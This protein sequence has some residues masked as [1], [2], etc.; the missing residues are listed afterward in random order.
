VHRV[1]KV[2]KVLE[3]HGVRRALILCAAI[4]ISTVAIAAQQAK[5]WQVP[6]TAWGDPDFDGIWNYAT[7]TPLERPREFADKA[8]LSPAEAAAYEQRTIDRQSTAN[9]TAGPDWWDP[10][11]RHLSRGRTSLIVDPVDGHL[12]PLTVEAQKAA[13]DRAQNRRRGPYEGPEDLALKERCLFWESAG[14]PMMPAPYNDDVQF[15]QTKD[16]VVIFN[17]M[18]H[19]AR[20]VPLDG[21]GHGKVSRWMG[22]SIGHWEGSTLV[23][24]TANFTDRTS[25]RGSDEHLRLIERFTRLG[26]DSMEYRFTMDDPT[27]W[28]RTWTAAVP[29]TRTSEPMYEYACHEG[30]ARSVEGMLRGARVQDTSPR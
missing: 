12:P 10:N 24:D 30:N 29:L 11:S 6:K 14:P 17:E 2:L 8:V 21:R 13:A 15:V 26:P 9:N 4:A 22:D 3:V 7:M 25:I 5:T 16:Y 18:I 1:H 20:I 23:V 28:T 27:I 19:D